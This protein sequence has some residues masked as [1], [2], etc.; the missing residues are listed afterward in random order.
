MLTVN[1]SPF[2]VLLTERLTLRELANTDA[3]DFF[4]LRANP[5]IMRFIPRPLAQTVEEA[6]L[7]IQ[8]IGEAIRKND[9]ITWAITRTPNKTVIGTIGYVRM[10]KEHYRAEVGYLLS[11]DYQGVGIMQEALTAVVGYGFRVMNL[12]S[13]EAIIDP[14]NT[15]S[16]KVLEKAGFIRE[17][18]F[19]ENQFVGG[20]FRDSV[21][22]SLLAP[23][24]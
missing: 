14:R 19:K 8:S 10:A 4:A 3:P 7:L 21:Y 5:D 15:A 13:I 12:H 1:F 18:W 2:P 17:G 11:A 16:A 23:V 22:Y 6:G 9:S 20:Q 24:K